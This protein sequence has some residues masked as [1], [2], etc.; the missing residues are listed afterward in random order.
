MKFNL[1]DIQGLQVGGN[2]PY[3]D[4]RTNQHYNLP[5]AQLGRKL[6]PVWE[7]PDENPSLLKKFTGLFGKDDGPKKPNKVRDARKK[8]RLSQQELHE[9]RKDLR[10]T[11]RVSNMGIR[12]RG[13][14]RK[15]S[16][17]EYKRRAIDDSDAKA[18]VE[19]DIRDQLSGVRGL[20]KSTV[21]QSNRD[22]RQT[23]LKGRFAR[24]MQ[25]AQE[26]GRQKE[27]KAA[28][29]TKLTPFMQEQLTRFQRNKLEAEG[30]R[31]DDRLAFGEG[32]KAI[33]FA[34]REETE[35]TRKYNDEKY[36]PL[37]DS[38][39]LT[40]EFGKTGDPTRMQYKQHEL[41]NPNGQWRGTE[42]PSVFD[43]KKGFPQIN[44]G[45]LNW[46][47]QDGGSV[48]SPILKAQTGKYTGGIE[49][50]AFLEPY[51][52]GINDTDVDPS[53]RL[54]DMQVGFKGNQQFSSS[55][56]DRP[57]GN[58]KEDRGVNPWRLHEPS[59]IMQ[60]AADA[61]PIG[62]NAMQ[63][64]TPALKEAPNYN[65]QS[66]AYLSGLRNLRA[67]PNYQ[68]ID[69]AQEAGMNM[70]RNNSRSTSQ[71]LGNMQQLQANMGRTRQD[72]AHK[73]KMANIGLEQGYLNALQNVGAQRNQ[74]AKAVAQRNIK[75]QLSKDMLGTK[76]A[77]NME[78]GLKN[79]GELMGS[80]K[81]NRMRVE[82]YL[83]QLTEDYK[84]VRGKNGELEIQFS[85]SG[86]SIPVDQLNQI[87][88][89]SEQ[90][91][92]DK[93]LSPENKTKSDK[94]TAKR[95]GGRLKRKPKRVRRHLY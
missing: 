92:V 46:F 52:F 16:E 9:G 83:N 90:D 89:D 45:D 15:T 36:R 32:K 86:K 61:I 3:R 60:S 53:T 66:D 29:R 68:P 48:N 33:K 35:R 84:Y 82:N 39:K 62:I 63:Y 12:E 94:S 1:R 49:Q 54:R 55:P 81:S 67:T 88:I 7:N 80:E 38:G 22:A 18:Q 65:K 28:S 4:M 70:I 75:H 95:M 87:L 30:L 71:L 64:A 40:R 74:E 19:Q 56:N 14:K 10:Q 79:Y 26:A 43:T 51:T 25:S 6:R 21:D 37:L 11:Q 91:T 20:S 50:G 42:L 44:P 85:S 77:D 72:A 2:I 58:I 13:A 76:L 27:G 59:N 5:K 57:K 93:S 17:L 31:V 78:Q 8:L 73:S 41:G 23:R 24:Q 34:D 47:R 69:Q